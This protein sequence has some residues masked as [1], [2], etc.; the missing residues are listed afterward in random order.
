MSKDIINLNDRIKKLNNQSMPNDPNFETNNETQDLDVEDSM[1]LG[2]SAFE[3]TLDDA[4]GFLTV[5]FDQDNQPSIIHAGELNLLQVVGSLEFIK[6]EI[7]NYVPTA[8]E[9]ARDFDEDL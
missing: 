5:T 6:N 7:L 4:K 9:F 1:E 3:D 2:L 8:E